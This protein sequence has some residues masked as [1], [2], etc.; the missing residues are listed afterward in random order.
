MSRDI[1]LLHP[2]LQRILKEMQDV[3]KAQG[4]SFIVPDGFRTMTEQNDLY[5]KGRTKAGQIVTNVRYPNSAHCWGIAFD[6]C[7][8]IQG[9]EYDDSDHF[10]E[11]VARIGKTYGLAWGGDWTSFIDKPHLYMSEYSPDGTARLLLDRWGSPVKFMQS[12]HNTVGFDDVHEEDWYAED[13]RWG[14]QLGIVSGYDDNTFRP[15]RKITRAEALSM[16]HRLWQE[17]Q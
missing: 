3:C 2:R 14:K 15:D 13:V 11:Q 6:F 16:L 5:A 7:R 10:F 17:L 4:L 8:S 12:W 9:L 1:T